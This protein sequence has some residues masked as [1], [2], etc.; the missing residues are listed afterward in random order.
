MKYK[1]SDPIEL[2]KKRDK[3]KH[4]LLS[5]DEVNKFTKDAY[6]EWREMPQYIQQRQQA[7]YELLVKFTSYKDVKEF[8]EMIGQKLTRKTKSIWH[9]IRVR[10]LH[11]DKRYK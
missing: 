9:P 7:K 11:S 10:G 1:D 6:E 3:D 4:G 8:A 5:L 2:A